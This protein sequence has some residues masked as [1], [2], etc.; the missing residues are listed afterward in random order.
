ML[1]LLKRLMSEVIANADTVH[2]MQVTEPIWYVFLHVRLQCGS[3]LI[4]QSIFWDVYI[5]LIYGILY[6]CFVAY[7]IVFTDLRGWSPGFTGLSFLGIAVGSTIVIAAEP[8]LRAFINRRKIDP[9]T[10]EKAPESMVSVVCVAAL[11]IP[12]GE[13]WFA[14]TCTPNVHWI[15]PI[16]AGEHINTSESPI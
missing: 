6:L 8:L 7:P 5:A 3:R 10:G 14:W 16:I 2:A 1:R 9:Q 11:L 4:F 13:I 15:V 12:I